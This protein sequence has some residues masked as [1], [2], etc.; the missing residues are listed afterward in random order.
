MVLKVQTQ[1]FLQLSF[2][3]TGIIQIMPLFYSIAKKQGLSAPFSLFETK[4]ESLINL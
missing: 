2:D 3:V 1:T 4:N